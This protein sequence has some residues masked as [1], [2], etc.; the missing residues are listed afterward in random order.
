M[1]KID[2]VWI[3]SDIPVPGWMPG[4]VYLAPAQPEAIC[5]LIQEKL[6]VSSAA[7][8]L[9]WDAT[10]GNP[11]ADRM[12]EQLSASED[13]W[14]AGL[15]LG[16]SGNPEMIDAVAPV[17]MLNRDPDPHSEAT[18]WRISLGCCLVRTEVLRQMGGVLPGFSS[19]AAA[20]LEM[21]YRYITKG[22]FCRHT[23]DLLPVSIHP[24]RL[25][26]PV[27]DQLR[28]L[29]V[30]FGMKWV[31]WACFRAVLNQTVQLVPMV[32][33]FHQLENF[34]PV[35]KNV[36][37]QRPQAEDG[38]PLI[39]GQV[40]VLIPTVNRYPYLRTLLGQLRT[41]TIRPFEILI[42]DQT[43]PE[44]RDKSIQQDFADLPIQWFE[45]DRAGQCSSRNLG[46]KHAQGDYI[47]F[48]DDDDEIPAN[49]IELHL[50]N[51]A[52]H[53]ARVSNGIANEVGAGSLPEN[54]TYL[55][56]S[57]VF[58][59]NNTLVARSILIKSGLFDLA[60][61]RGQRAD[62]D[63]GMR[64]YLS[65]EK[66]VLNPAIAVL[67]HHAPQ[68]GLRE[69]KARV[70]TYAASRNTLNL[71]ILPSVSEIYLSKRY[72][73]S[74]QVQEEMWVALL[75]TFS[76]RGHAFRKLLKGILSLV[77]LPRTIFAMRDRIRK[78]DEWMKR[79]PQIPHLEG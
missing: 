15:R 78:A 53:H 65:G 17:W 19:L 54:F 45:L 69:H 46:L 31:I 79:Y 57:D 5:C 70:H 44:H 47:L 39:L 24:P 52:I 61:D 58:P 29:K 1:N 36:L 73:T 2:L 18:S 77:M 20:G 55:R 10:L 7:A 4:E 32:K 8:W 22:V 51:L 67:H 71:R 75:G 59:T 62:G 26:I 27:L 41:Q 35:K 9:F 72:F 43:P 34:A 38:S 63:L 68:G 33:A 76:I 28:F 64:V 21:G 56:M 14:H 25:E 13:V 16:T 12:I 49:L 30:S 74:H 48:I 50:K 42:I 40:S 66:M 3:G 37:F 11:D 60:Y 6:S 23:P